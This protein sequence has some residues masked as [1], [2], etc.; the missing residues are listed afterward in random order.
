MKKHGMTQNLRGKQTMKQDTPRTTFSQYLGWPQS[1]HT[2]IDNTLTQAI[3]PIVVPGGA[4]RL[5]AA[6]QTKLQTRQ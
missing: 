6:W 5:E 3:N 2:P 1:G 4:L